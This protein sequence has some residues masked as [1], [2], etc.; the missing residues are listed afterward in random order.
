MDSHFASRKWVLALLALGIAIAA[1]ALHWIDGAQLV[2]LVTWT[3][4]LYMAGNVGQAVA[5]KI[6]IGARP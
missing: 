5:D 2:S 6:S 1:R 4:G 3:T